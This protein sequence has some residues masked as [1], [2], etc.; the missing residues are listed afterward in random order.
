MQ[1]F[2]GNSS[3]KEI[4]LKTAQVIF[5]CPCLNHQSAILLIGMGGS[6]DEESD[7]DLSDVPEVDSDVEQEQQ[8][9]YDRA[10]Y[11]EDLTTLKTKLSHTQN[12]QGSQ[13]TSSQTEKRQKAPARSLHL[14]FV[15]G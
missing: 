13:P 8:V 6:A 12:D 11:K 2:S 14:E 5:M 1:C 15:H 4:Q 9:K 10:V 3:L 7:S